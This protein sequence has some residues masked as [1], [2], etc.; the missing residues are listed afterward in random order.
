MFE[1]E[2]EGENGFGLFD[3]VLAPLHS[4]VVYESKPPSSSSSRWRG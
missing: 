4:D 3:D 2:Y 1:T